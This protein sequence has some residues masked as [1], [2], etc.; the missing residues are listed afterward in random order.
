[1][2]LVFRIFRIEKQ[3]GTP[4]EL[5]TVLF[6][7]VVG[8]VCTFG[9]LDMFGLLNGGGVRVVF[10][11]ECLHAQP[12]TALRQ[13]R[14]GRFVY[15]VSVFDAFHSCFQCTGYSARIVYMYHDIGAPI[16]GGPNGRLQLFVKEFGHVQRVV[17]RCGTSA[18][19]E[20]YLR[21]PFFQV[22]P[23]SGRYRDGAVDYSG[24]AEFFDVCQTAAT[25]AV[26]LFVDRTE[27]AVSRGLGNHGTARIDARAFQNA[28]VYGAFQSE[29]GAARIAYGRES[30]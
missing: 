30:S 3:V 22:L 6:R 2:I 9:D 5:D 16:F 15:E 18:G 11:S 8:T 10:E 19:H 7:Q 21:G 25:V 28:V 17:Q 27:I 13:Q 23:D 26:R 14:H 24:C 12:C 1:M 29:D 4:G 20:F